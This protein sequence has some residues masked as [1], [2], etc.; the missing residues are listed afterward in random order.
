MFGVVWDYYSSKLKGKQYQQNTTPKS[1]NTEL[2]IL[3][4]PG[5]AKLGSEQP[6]PDPEFSKEY[7]MLD[8][9]P[10]NS[11]T[12]HLYHSNPRLVWPPMTLVWWKCRQLS[13]R[14]TLRTQKW[15]ELCVQEMCPDKREL[16]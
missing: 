12:D 10:S 15:P 11:I 5:L 16:R 4:N 9:S 13:L 7:S 1:Y 2:K 8:P 3:A 14:G 6:G